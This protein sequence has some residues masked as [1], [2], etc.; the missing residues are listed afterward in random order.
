MYMIENKDYFEEK[1]KKV[2]EL[3]VVKALELLNQA[4]PQNEIE[5]K[6][7]EFLKES[8]PEYLNKELKSYYQRNKFEAPFLMNEEEGEV[9]LVN[10]KGI[11]L[12]QMPKKP[13]S[14]KKEIHSNRAFIGRSEM[15][16]I[17]PGETL[18]LKD[19]KIN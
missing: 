14:V 13:Q 3:N 12:S 4:K 2:Q 11:Q 8:L 10:R 9:N 18:G 7:S 5:A 15:P 16:V 1:E 17:K 19:I 6:I